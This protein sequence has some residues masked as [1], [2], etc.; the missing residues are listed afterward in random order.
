MRLNI[1][2]FSHLASPRTHEGAAAVVLTS[3]QE[4]RRS[5]LSC[6]LWEHEFYENRRADCR[7]HP[8]L[9]PG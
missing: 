6:M 7:P 5:V 2:K 8:R 9:V 1:L 4:L 3:E